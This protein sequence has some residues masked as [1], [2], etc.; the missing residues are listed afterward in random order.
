[1]VGKVLEMLDT[2]K[3]RDALKNAKENPESERLQ[4]EIQKI[5]SQKMEREADFAN[6]I[7]QLSQEINKSHL[8]THQIPHQIRRTPAG[9][10][11]RDEEVA[12]ILDQIDK[13][14]A[15]IGINGMGGI[16]KTALALAVSNRIKDRFPDGQIFLELLGTSENP[17]TPA[18]AMS[19]V[20]QAFDPKAYLPKTE[21]G[22]NGLYATVLTDKNALLLLDNA[23]NREQVELLLPPAGSSLII[24]SEFSFVL[25]GLKEIELESLPPD[26]AKNLLLEI[27]GRI[28]EKADDIAE[29]CGYLPL[30]LHNAACILAETKNIS[31]AEYIKKLK[32]SKSRLKLVDATFS[33]SY[34]LLPPNLKEFWGI[35]SIFP[36]DFDNA[37]AAFVGKMDS[38]DAL[39]SLGELIRRSLIFYIPATERDE[40]GRYLLHD[41][42][43]I[44][45]NTQFALDESKEFE[46]QQLHAEYYQLQLQHANDLY[47]HGDMDLLHGLKLFDLER[48]NIVH[49]QKW[50]EMNTIKSPK[51]AAI[52]S[53]FANSENVLYMRLHSNDYIRWLESAIIADRQI[54]DQKSEANHLRILASAHRELSEFEKSVEQSKESLN[55]AKNIDDR[56]L[57]VN[58]LIELANGYFA[59]DKYNDAISYYETALSVSKDIGYPRGEGGALRGLGITY[60]NIGLARRSIDYQKKYLKI[61][62][63]LG[64]KSNEGKAY[65]N[66]GRAYLDIGDVSRGIRCHELQLTMSR[67]IGDRRGEGR[68]LSNLGHAYNHEFEK[69]IKYSN[70]ALKIFQETGDLLWESDTRCV[71]ALAYINQGDSERAIEY[72][73][74]SLSISRKIK[75]RRGEGSA[76]GNL[77]TAYG[78][79]K[80][81]KKAIEFYQQ[82]LL[83]A[84]EIGDKMG[85]GNALFNISNCQYDIEQCENAII[86][87]KSALEIYTQ[88]ECPRADNVRRKL[89]EWGN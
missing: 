12:S 78:K 76:L 81:F 84:R 1:L 74:Q 35:V 77:G 48:P 10:K 36:S 58:A 17:L 67:E 23:A 55:I 82:R 21:N 44:Y 41:L 66:L 43:R 16:G 31:V 45:A 56:I 51:I 26:D 38:I 20:I 72:C 13:G 73:N 8:I 22:I 39:D 65:G 24:T 87:A 53:K 2:G 9:F 3:E 7:T 52:C 46:A 5:I 79:Q 83:I 28:G 59:L 18:V 63:K 33:L 27:D 61:A 37:G 25:P 64:D 14:D 30:A 19:H 69:S 6:V 49:G 54:K 4:N 57:Q 85:E 50:A 60:R 88:I 15:I 47:L 80:K 71:L 40:V 62:H 89:E 32:D 70:M 29:L 34:K 75:D 42:A 86:S 11:D 68:A